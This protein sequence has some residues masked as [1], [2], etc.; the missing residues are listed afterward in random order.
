MAYGLRYIIQQK[1][2]N[3]DS[4]LVRIY[5]EG[6]VGSTY[7]YIPQNIAIQPNSNEEDAI[8][9]ILSSQLNISFIIST[10][11][12]YDNF[13]ELLSY[14]DTKYYV[15]LVIAG[16]VTWKGFLLNDYIQVA[17][18]TGNQEVSMTCIDGLSLLR[19]QFY[20]SSIDINS[21]TQLI[22]VIGEALSKLVYNSPSYIYACCSYYAL[23]MLNRGD[24]PDAEP[25][26]QTYQYRRDYFNLDYYS[27]LENIVKSFGCRLFQSNGDWYILPMN[28]MATT[29]YYT[30][31]SVTNN[32]LLQSSGV[33]SNSVTIAPYA[34]NNV[35]FID[36]SQTKIVRK[37]YPKIV[38]SIPYTSCDNYLHNATFKQI[39][40]GKAVGW[41]EYEVAPARIDLLLQPDGQFNAYDLFAGST[42]SGIAT[43]YNAGTLG[44]GDD[45]LPIMYGPSASLSFEYYAPLASNK[46]NVGV[47]IEYIQAGVSYILWLH[48]NNEWKDTQYFFEKTAGT[49]FSSNAYSNQSL[50]IP[51]GTQKINS[52]ALGNISVMLF[53][54][55]T[56]LFNVDRVKGISGGYVRNVILKQDKAQIEEVQIT[57][58]IG[59]STLEK[60]IDISYG[61]LYPETESYEQYNYKGVFISSPVALS[62]NE[63]LI[64]WYRYGKPAESFDSLPQLIMRQYSSLL[65]KN[66]ATLEGDLGAYKGIYGIN[67]LDKT[68][69]IEDSSTNALSYN[70][71]KFLANRLTVNPYTDEVN[72]LQLIEITNTDNAATEK[73][74]YIGDTR[75]KR[76][77]KYIQ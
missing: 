72:S 75:L 61:A 68:Y 41:Y 42:G 71:K 15:E 53:G 6:Y 49:T 17:Y 23:G 55:I 43:L 57:L 10:Q 34:E 65:N 22:D 5:D 62:P 60:S 13:P 45:Y 11:A 37:G 66:I 51:L 31:Y 63:L 4:L 73:I 44:Y 47:T 50:S 21:T 16:E 19:Y 74:E 18:T 26:S 35:H 59:T 58:S 7:S 32:P 3:D 30:K 56:V 27:I 25:F 38:S 33:L 36:N 12:D 8:A 40:A 46:I 1:L 52:F 9:G 48:N 29:V 24:S 54:R 69:T 77:T 20:D 67:Y 2:R 64:N 70:G 28:Q 14:N 39:S 76:P